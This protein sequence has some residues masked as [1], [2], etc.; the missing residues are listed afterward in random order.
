[1]IHRRREETGGV[2]HRPGT[3][4]L[5]AGGILV[6]WCA[7]MTHWNLYLPDAGEDRGQK[8]KRASENE[9]AGWHHRCDGHELGQTPGDGE[10]QGGLVC[11]S[12][13]GRKE[14]DTTEQVNKT[15]AWGV[16]RP[17]WVS[18]SP[19][20]RQPRSRPCSPVSSARYFHPDTT[21]V[22]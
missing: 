13:R 18:C 3:C 17:P 4:S 11:H 7:Q 5:L 20:G 19:P 14:S 9:T 22:F 12:P 2:A 10:G 15:T 16:H 1:M 8:E 21:N 6:I